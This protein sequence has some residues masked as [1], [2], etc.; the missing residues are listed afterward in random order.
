MTTEKFWA[1]MSVVGFILIFI[2]PVPGVL[3]FLLSIS[4]FS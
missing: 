4:F 2:A 1:I 3:L